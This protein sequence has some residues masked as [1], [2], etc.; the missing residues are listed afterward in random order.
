MKERT[1]IMPTSNRMFSMSSLI[2][3]NNTSTSK[4]AFFS[5]NFV[6]TQRHSNSHPDMIF[7]FCYS[8]ILLDFLTYD[9]KLL[10]LFSSSKSPN[11]NGD[12]WSD[13]KRCGRLDLCLQLYSQTG[14]DMQLVHQI[15]SDSLLVDTC[16]SLNIIQ[17]SSVG[18]TLTIFSRCN[19][20]LFAPANL[21]L[22]YFEIL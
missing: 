5:S 20:S 10:R 21:V 15:A 2:F 7:V 1:N 8:N 11:D 3:S 14:H 19:Y 22:I 6:L 18:V 17:L 4:F 16:M 12:S 9:K 13:A